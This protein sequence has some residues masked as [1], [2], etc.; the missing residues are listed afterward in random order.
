VLIT[1]QRAHP[2]RRRIEDAGRWVLLRDVGAPE[3]D[4]AEHVAHALLRR[5]GVVFHKVLEREIALPPWRELLRVYWRLEA[6]G[7]LRG[8]RFIEGFAG[9]Q[10]ALPEAV[11]LL[12]ELRR[13]PRA[14]APVRIAASDPLNLTGILL[15]GARVAGRLG[16]EVEMGTF[17]ISPLAD[18]DVEAAASA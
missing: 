14:V 6:R 8:G 10:F 17:L 4:A 18:A 2:R 16:A 13:H 5:Y 9:E 1:P 11:G 12:R 3:P 15:P 7:E